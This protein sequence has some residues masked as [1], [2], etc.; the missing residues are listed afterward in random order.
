V[1][2]CPDVL[3]PF[4]KRWLTDKGRVKVFEKSRRIGATWCTGAEA[5]LQASCMDGQDVWYVS[6]NEDSA[7]EFIRDC[8]KWCKWLG[9]A[10]KEMGLVI[11]HEGEDGDLKGVRAF[12]ITFPYS[13]FRVTALT[14]SARN[15]RGKQG[16]VII[17]EAAFHDNLP[18]LLKAAFAL[19]MWGGSVWIM[20][21]HNGVDNAFADLCDQ[22]RDGKRPYSL[23]KVTIQDALDEGLYA[24]I[25][26]VLGEPYSLPKEQAWLRDLER[27]YGDGVREELY[28]E[29]NKGGQAYLGRPLIEACMFEPPLGLPHPVV[30]IER[31][32]EWTLLP[33]AQRTAELAEWCDAILAPLLSHLPQGQPHAFG[34]DFGRY[35]DRSVLAPFT[36]EQDLTR[37]CPF[38]LE[39]QGIPHNDQ[40]QLMQYIATRL[41]SL[42]KCWLDAGGNGSWIAEQALVT[43]GEQ[44]VTQCDLTLGFYATYMPLLREAHERGV[45]KYP[46]DLDIRGDMELI[47]RIDGVPRLPK[48]RTDAQLG[49]KKRHGDAAIAIMLGYAAASEADAENQRWSALSNPTRTGNARMAWT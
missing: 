29:P 47:R 38:I 16:L 35:A 32:E 12:Q 49:G 3:L 42:Y 8:V 17:D 6:Y 18:E 9:I 13:A 4:Q 24:R 36:L 34:W 23:H 28:C 33:Q 40:W 46:R 39:C 2:D 43:W 25:C 11:L 30:R 15:L 7:K 31:D 5:V 21:T 19:L 26:A 20:S 10:A 1:S 37:R 44:I 27:E 48:E 45:I 22:I 41:P 14:S